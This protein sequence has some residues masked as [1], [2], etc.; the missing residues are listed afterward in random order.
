MKDVEG[1]LLRAV[2]TGALVRFQVDLDHDQLPLRQLWLRP[3]CNDL[4]QKPGLLTATQIEVVR[5]AFRRF[6]VG[7]RFMVVTADSPHREVQALGD[8]R[9]LK[10]PRPPFVEVRFRPPPHDLRLFGRFVRMD[11]L[12]LTTHGAKARNSKTGLKPLTV[13][14]ERSRCDA[15][16]VAAGLQL[17]WVPSEIRDSISNASFD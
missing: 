1:A 13:P 2:Q 16:F 11:A 4:L 10:G 3:I 8:I 15:S 5:A 12:V 9:E 7:G 6:I 17:E 14:N